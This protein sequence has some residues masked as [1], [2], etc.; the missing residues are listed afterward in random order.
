MNHADKP[1]A[2]RTCK[3]ELVELTLK[4]QSSVPMS[5][6]LLIFLPGG[7]HLEALFWRLLPQWSARTP[8][9]TNLLRLLEWASVA[10]HD[11]HRKKQR[12]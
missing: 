1:E 5:E 4:R 6:L 8:S 3:A 10:A 11:L 7:A 2:F 12:A 9:S